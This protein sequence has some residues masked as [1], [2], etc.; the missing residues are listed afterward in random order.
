MT[1]QQL[2]ERIRTAQPTVSAAD[3]KRVLDALP[4]ALNALL[5]EEG[6]FAWKG[7]GAFRRMVRKGRSGRN[8]QTGEEI[9]ILPSATVG[10]RPGSQLKTALQEWLSQQPEDIEDDYGDI[11]ADDD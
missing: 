5:I 6:A 3:I 9:R 11:N 8:P 4:G 10:F 7:L 2:V 1:Q